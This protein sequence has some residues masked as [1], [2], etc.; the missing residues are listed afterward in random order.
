MQFDLESTICGIATGQQPG[1]RG[2]IRISGPESLTV[3]QRFERIRVKLDEAKNP[4]RISLD[5]QLSPPLSSVPVDL[6]IW[7]TQRSYTG[8]PSVE[9]HT[10]GQPIILQSIVE[11]LCMNGAK[12]AQP[13]EFTLRAFLAGR[14]DL[15]QCEAVLGV[16]EAKSEMALDVAL[17]QLGGGLS[18][19]LK[20]LRTSLLELLA[21][22]EAGLDFVDEDIEFISP[23]EVQN[24]LHAAALQIALL[25]TQ[26]QQRRITN[27]AAKV[28]LVGLP[29]AGKSSLL[30]AIVGRKVAIVNEQAG[31][32]RDYL[33]VT[34]SLQHGKVEWI[35]TAGIEEVNRDSTIASITTAAQNYRTEQLLQADL[36]LYC[37]E[38]KQPVAP[39]DFPYNTEVWLVRTKCDNDQSRLP[40]SSQTCFATQVNTSSHHSYG[41]QGLIECA[42]EWLRQRNEEFAA[43]AP[44]TATRCISLLK[45]AS[46][47]IQR[48]SEATSHRLG[49]EL[50][51]GEIR[52]TLDHLGQVAGEV[53]TDDVLDALF[54]RF[55]IGK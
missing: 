27:E 41:I 4:R 23:R 35:D 51:C 28:A 32:T 9:L 36:I 16:I 52:L 13:G 34:T 3:L 5:W 47:S 19:P 53:Y 54:S 14:M 30:N 40:E 8:M 22:I 15:T 43:V 18:E 44:L 24:R 20:E 49:D 6:W 50:V 39:N 12:L 31:T 42:D 33:R 46:E 1:Q 21:D 25:L 38:E 26:I 29:N 17:R 2:A 55:C 7:P 10:I 48:A 37:V 11:Q 45:A